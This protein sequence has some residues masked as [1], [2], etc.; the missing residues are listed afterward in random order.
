MYVDDKSAL[1]KVWSIDCQQKVKRQKK[2]KNKNKTKQNKKT[3]EKK[4]KKKKSTW[5]FFFSLI[6]VFC[7]WYFD[8]KGE[9]EGGYNIS[10][11]FIPV[12]LQCLSIDSN[13]ISN[14]ICHGLFFMFNELTWEVIVCFVDIDEI[15]DHLFSWQ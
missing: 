8:R 7:Y 3:K 11:R 2:N 9:K 13:C 12:T 10:N 14:G 1:R 5:T 6:I 15:V 4:R